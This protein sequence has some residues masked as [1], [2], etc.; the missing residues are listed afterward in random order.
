MKLVSYQCNLH[1]FIV[2]NAIYVNTHSF[3][4]TNANIASIFSNYN[5][6]NLI[7]SLSTISIYYSLIFVNSHHCL[8]KPIMP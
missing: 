4:F 5:G 6:V 7:F 1:I 3:F 8:T 2:V